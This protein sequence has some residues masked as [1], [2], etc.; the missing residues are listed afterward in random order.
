MTGETRSRRCRVSRKTGIQNRL[1][2]THPSLKGM[3][4][5]RTIEA[6]IALGMI[7]QL[8]RH[9]HDTG[10]GM[11]DQTEV[12]GPMENFPALIRFGSTQ[13]SHLGEQPFESVQ[14]SSLEARN[15]QT[16]GQR[17]QTDAH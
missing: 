1:V 8:G 12:K 6:S 14:L 10:T 11:G 7:G 13:F 9:F 3:G 4:S 2:F 15:S 17:F 5:L 16:N